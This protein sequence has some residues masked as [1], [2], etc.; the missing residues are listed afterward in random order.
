MTTGRINQVTILSQR[1]EALRQTPKKGASCTKQ[2]TLKRPRSPPSQSTRQWECERPIQL[3]PL[4]SPKAGP[5]RAMVDVA[6]KNISATYS[7]QE[8]KTHASTRSKLRK[9]GRVV[10]KGLVNIW[11]K[12]AIHSPQ[13]VPVKMNWRGFSP[14]YKS[15]SSPKRICTPDLSHRVAEASITRSADSLST[16]IK[17]TRQASKIPSDESMRKVEPTTPPNFATSQP[18]QILI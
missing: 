1:A 8:E 3:P 15:K 4:S 10:P 2:E 7:L 18:A 5:Q 16:G 9:L 6:V 13:M 11:S 17:G 12:P 14:G